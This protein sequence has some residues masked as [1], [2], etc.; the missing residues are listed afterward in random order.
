MITHWNITFW[1]KK[2]FGIMT[3]RNIELPS[4]YPITTN[5]PSFITVAH[6][7]ICIFAFFVTSQ[8][9]QICKW[10][11]KYAHSV[12]TDH[13]G[14]TCA[15]IPTYQVLR[16]SDVLIKEAKVDFFCWRATYIYQYIRQISW[17][18]KSEWFFRQ[19]RHQ[20]L[21]PTPLVKISHFQTEFCPFIHV[22][23]PSI[24]SSPPP[25]H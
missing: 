23:C 18:R 11:I 20:A 7:D 21:P 16:K 15:H 22:F 13:V 24:R 3:P 14:S 2:P 10:G 8:S 1:N 4:A 17:R 6:T 5:I 25:P 19:W 9:E 12:T